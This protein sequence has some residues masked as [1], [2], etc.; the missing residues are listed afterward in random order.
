[1]KQTTPIRPALGKQNKTNERRVKRKSKKG[2][3]D[4]RVDYAFKC[5][6][7]CCLDRPCEKCR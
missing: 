5:E 3:F 1:M 6:Y 4:I 2:Y 7:K